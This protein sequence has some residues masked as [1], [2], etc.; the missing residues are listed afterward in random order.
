MT[1]LVAVI[2]AFAIATPSAQAV[3]TY[4]RKLQSVE[5]AWCMSALLSVSFGVGYDSCDDPRARWH[6]L[7]KSDSYRGTG[8]EVWQIKSDFYT[9]KCIIAVNADDGDLDLGSCAYSG[10][11]HNKFEVF[12]TTRNGE[13]IYQ[14]KDIEAWEN[15]GK[16]RCISDNSVWPLMSECNQVYNSYWDPASW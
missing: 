3:G 11:V 16:H 8:H 12:R 7:V 13:N 6:V 10:S 15:N 1:G 14:L 4:N 9:D 2:F 5:S